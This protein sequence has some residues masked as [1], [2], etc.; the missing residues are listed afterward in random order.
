MEIV[1]DKILKEVLT[2]SKKEDKEYTDKDIKNQLKDL[3]KVSKFIRKEMENKYRSIRRQALNKVK[4]ENKDIAKIV[5]DI[6]DNLLFNR[7][8]RGG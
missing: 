4:K 8:K 5:I 6:W 2:E 7:G 3:E 1:V